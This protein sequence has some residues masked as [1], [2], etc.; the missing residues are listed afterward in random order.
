MYQDN[1]SLG[2]GGGTPGPPGSVGADPDRQFSGSVPMSGGLPSE[3][4][5]NASTALSA[6]VASRMNRATRVK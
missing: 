5:R 2:R 4:T 1:L 6:D 3:P